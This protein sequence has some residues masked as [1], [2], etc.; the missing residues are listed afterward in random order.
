MC[1]GRSSFTGSFGRH[2]P[3]HAE[4]NGGGG[5]HRVSVADVA[6]DRAGGGGVGLGQRAAAAPGADAAVRRGPG[7]Q[8]ARQAAASSLAMGLAHW[9]GNHPREA[10]AILGSVKNIDIVSPQFREAF[11]ELRTA[12]QVRVEAVE[13]RWAAARPTPYQLAPDGK[14]KLNP[15]WFEGHLLLQPEMHVLP[16]PL[17]GDQTAGDGSGGLQEVRG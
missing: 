6:A 10:R 13:R 12:A 14:P 7:E 17:A 15:V 3:V 9:A 5:R 16:G 8:V 2:P 1:P 11:V 4:G